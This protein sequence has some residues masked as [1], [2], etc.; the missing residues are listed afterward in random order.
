M[1]RSTIDFLSRSRRCYAIDLPGHGESGDRQHGW[2]SIRN[3]AG[4]VAEVCRKLAVEDPVLVGHSMGGT[5]ALKIAAS[6]LVEMSQIVAV[7]P[8]VRGGTWARSMNLKGKFLAR[9]VMPMRMLWPITSRILDGPLR[10]FSRRWPIHVRR[11]REDLSRTS[12][13]AALGAIRAVLM[14]D[15]TR[16]LRAIRVPTLII[17]GESDPTVP[18]S[19]GHLAAQLIPSSSLLSLPSGHHPMDETPD[20]F[21]D[22]LGSF[23]AI[24]EDA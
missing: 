13:D 5:I 14:E 2:Y 1:W 8:L 4:F 7:N 3:L 23:L 15:L 6:K 11:N 17:V 18:P 10:P 21:L 9:L 22:A 16:P 19:E 12:P 24:S 20:R